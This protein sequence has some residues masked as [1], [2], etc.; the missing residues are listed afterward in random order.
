MAQL[1]T[2]TLT[3]LFTDIEGSTRLLHELG[4][5]FGPT[6]ERH[7][8][9][10]RDAVSNH[11]G[12]EVHTEG[13][14]FFCVFHTAGEGLAAAAEIQRS[15][16][17][18]D[19]IDGNKVSVR[20][21]VLTGVAILGG[22]D[23]VGLDVHRAARISET[24]H[25]GQIL[26]SAS[27]RVLGEA[28]LP[29]GVTML[30][31]G[32]FHLR[33]LDEPE[34]LFQLVI[35]GLNSTFPPLRKLD[36]GP[37]NLPVAPSSFVGRGRERQ[38]V[39]KLLG[40]SRLV[41]ITGM[42][43]AGKS[44]LALEVAAES[45]EA[46]RDGIW[47]MG[48]APVKTDD[49]VAQAVAHAIG[50][51]ES[52]SR[53]AVDVLIEYLGDGSCL[54]VLDNCEHVIDGVGNLVGVLGAAARNVRVL[55]TSRQVLG[56]PGEARYPC[57]PLGTPEESTTSLSGVLDFDSV[58]L[59][60]TRAKEVDPAFGIGDD[61]AAVIA[62]ICRRLDGMPLAIELA[63]AMVRILTPQEI[64]DRL[65][66]RFDLLTGGP[67]TAPSH[68]QT[69][70]AALDS[71]FELL[72][73]HQQEFAARIG[74][75]VGSF[76]AVAAEAVASG[77]EIPRSGVIGGLSALVDRSLITSRQVG[78]ELRLT[79]L[80]SVRQYLLAELE[81]RGQL[82]E[83]RIAHAEYFED[84]VK[85]AS[86]GL[87]GPDQ[88][89]WAARVNADIGNVRSAITFTAAQGDDAA[90]RIANGTLL[91]WLTRGDWSDGLH[92]T[93]VAL[94][95]TSTEDS[96]LRA[97]MLASAGFFASD[98]GEAER[99]IADLEEGLAMARRVDDLHAQGYCASFLGA[100]LSRRDMDLDRGLALLIEAQGIYSQLSEPYGEAWVIRYLGLSYQERGDLEEAIR[101]HSRSLETF[102]EVGDVWNIRRSQALLAE[103]MH[104][105]GELSSSRDLYEQSLRGPSDVRF[106]VVIAHALKGLGKVSLANGQLDEASDHLCEALSELQAIGDVAGAAETRGH[107]AMVELGRGDWATAEEGLI[108]SLCTFREMNDQGGVAWSLERLAAV[109][110]ARSSFEKAARLLGAGA[111][112]RERTGSRRARVDQPDFDRLMAATR[113]Q[114]GDEAA[115]AETQMGAELDFEAA[116]TLGTETR[117]S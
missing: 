91:F 69:L 71:T 46:Y 30:D 4:S 49:L 106:K 116:V 17:A 90:L 9:L 24:G 59:F 60:D 78:G 37:S 93:R 32:E 1:P 50:L 7:Q 72:D 73:D 8:V 67:R 27:T 82:E 40:E 84:L 26:V 64:L 65:D 48:M 11:D 99:G 43:G 52:A 28:G 3:F 85:A 79:V 55:V 34:H 105:I 56:I 110:A 10:V 109:A 95:H 96:A 39:E 77:G 16:A 57:P 111:G 89:T 53:S 33:D 21:G 6:L 94:D 42:A 101:L 20:I 87:R 97:R 88:D 100:E 14:S 36:L 51:Q 29:V 80:E 103:A 86:A 104:T 15:M 68:Q 19:W 58:V 113:E 92:W 66:Q 12:V 2:G 25:G 114:L 47:L 61:N 81:S 63:A 108:E 44:R 38:A 41:T 75:F 102:R 74:V 13:D 76:D 107:L 54:I 117:N 115:A 35:Q 18:E 112:I 22:D 45:R 62:A 98:L 31:L 83:R 23:Y 70:R 5:R